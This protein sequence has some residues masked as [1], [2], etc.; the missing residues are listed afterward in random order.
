VTVFSNTAGRRRPYARVMKLIAALA[1]ATAF[2][3]F[4][5]DAGKANVEIVPIL[6]V[7]KI[8]PSM[9]FWVDKLGFENKSEVRDGARLAFVILEKNGARLMLQTRAAALKDAPVLVSPHDAPALLYVVVDD[10]GPIRSRIAECDIVV[11]E[12]VMPY[13]KR[14][15]AVREPGG[16]FVMFAAPVE[17]QPTN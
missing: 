6:T 5:A 9:P 1:L 4:G 14:E 11:P 7:E 15:I 12:R 16:H 8:E 17:K 3:A 2:N 10:L 13:G